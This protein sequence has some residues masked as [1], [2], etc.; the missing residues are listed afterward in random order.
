[1]SNKADSIDQRKI[2]RRSAWMRVLVVL[3][4]GILLFTI[5]NLSHLRS[6][7]T[8]DQIYSLSDSTKQVLDALDEPLMIRAYITSDMPQPYGR[9]QGFIEDMLQSYYEAG[10]GKV[11][12]DVMDPASDVNVMASLKALNIPK[13]QVQVVE[14]DRAQVKQGYL[15]IVLEYLDRKE[16]ISVVQSE[17]GF[18]YLLTKKIKKLTGKGRVKIGLTSAFGAHG[19]GE[20]QRFSTWMKDDYEFVSVDLTKAGVPDDVRAVIV[21]GMTQAPSKAWRFRLDQFR[22]HGGGVWVLAGS[23]R[24]LLSKGFDVQAVDADA[25]DW[26]HDDLNIS[27]ESGLV[28]DKR[29]QRVV[30]RNGM[31]ES[32]VDYPFVPNVL[33]L[34]KSHVISRGLESVSIPFASPLLAVDGKAQVLMQSSP[35]TAVQDG[36]PFDVYPLM[37]IDKRFE[38]LQLK[39]EVL[40]LAQEGAMTSAFKSL[41]QGMQGPLLTHVDS[42]RLLVIGSPGMLDDEFMDGSALI[43]ALNSLDWLSYDEALIELRSRGVTERPL[44]ALS[45]DGKLVFKLLWL[46][47]LPL[48]VLLFGLW[49]WWQLRH[50]VVNG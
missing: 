6:D 41:P 9:L 13:V 37:A 15:A 1:M 45:S 25:N 34:N 48:L 29:A 36:P 44:A 42:G 39:S 14:N 31:F 2:M 23:A 5:T 8:E 26:V 20:L 3:L 28:M 19:L 40:A 21:D 18:E 32:Q 24:P 50:P 17:E 46:F 22:M 47:A 12:F 33:D 10:H 11:G 49:R 27:V 43:L 35:W 4:F 30:V 38:G 16:V 7:W